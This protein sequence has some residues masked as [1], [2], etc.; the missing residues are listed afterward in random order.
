MLLIS[1][2]GVDSIYLI[3]HFMKKH[4]WSFDEIINLPPIETN[5]FKTLLLNEQK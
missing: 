4:N 3:I 5:I 2:G 1:L